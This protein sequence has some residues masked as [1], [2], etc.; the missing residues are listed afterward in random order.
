MKADLLALS[1]SS[2]C[3]KTKTVAV[4]VP[5]LDSSFVGLYFFIEFLRRLP[6]QIDPCGENR[7]FHSFGYNGPLFKKPIDIQVIDI[8]DKSD[9]L[10][11]A[12][13]LKKLYYFADLCS[14]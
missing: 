9:T 2:R 13:G 11:K 1:Y 8:F 14:K 5:K 12:R 7:E 10:D 6:M 4:D 3:F